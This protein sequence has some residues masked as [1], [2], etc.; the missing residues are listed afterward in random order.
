M[1]ATV[2]F[3]GTESQLAR[4]GWFGN[5]LF[6]RRRT[7]VIRPG[8]GDTKI[9]VI[10]TSM[11]TPQG[12]NYLMTKRKMVAIELRPPAPSRGRSSNVS[13]KLRV[14]NDTDAVSSDEAKKTNSNMPG[15][16]VQMTFKVYEVL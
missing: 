4:L 1:S 9:Q 15:I 10:C 13:N 14:S 8:D 7:C 12:F 16:P 2:V 11:A 6:G 5:P 3:E